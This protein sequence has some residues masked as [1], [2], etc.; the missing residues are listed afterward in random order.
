MKNNDSIAH[1]QELDNLRRQN[2]ELLTK[3]HKLEKENQTYRKIIDYVTGTTLVSNESEPCILNPEMA[4]QIGKYVK[5]Q[6]SYEKAIIASLD[7]IIFLLDGSYAFINVWTNQPENLFLPIEKL[8]GK[9]VR[10]ALGEEFAI[11]FEKLIDRVIQTKERQSIEYL[12][13]DKVSY[14]RAILNY[15]LTD[16]PSS[17]LVSC[18]IRDITQQKKTQEALYNSEKKFRMLVNASYDDIFITNAEGKFI[19]VNQNI[20]DELGY[21]ETELLQMSIFQ[22]SFG[23][24]KFSNLMQVIRQKG[25]LVFDMVHMSKAGE[26]IPVELNM[27]FTTFEGEPAYLGIA[28]NTTER[29]KSEA[30]LRQY[31]NIIDKSNDAIFLIEPKTGKYIDC[32]QKACDILG[33][34]KEELLQKGVIDIAKHISD[35]GILKRRVDFVKKKNGLVFETEYKHKKGS[36]IP[37]EVSATLIDYLNHT[38][39]LAMVRDI[40]KRKQDEKALYQA[41]MVIENSPAVL[42]RRRADKG[43]PVELV[44]GNIIQF[45]YTAHELLSGTISYVDLIH[46]DDLVRVNG[47]TIRNTA[48]ARARF[49][50]EY[51][52]LTAKGDV[53]WVDD[54]TL[55]ERDSRG[56]VTHYQGI[57]MDV[58]D[59]KEA[60]IE[61]QR[62]KE[63][64]AQTN[65]V[66]KVGGWEYDLLKNTLYWSDVTKI[67][68]EV[69]LYFEPNIE[70]AINFYKEG[71]SR[72]RMSHALQEAIEK[73]EPYNLELQIV[74]VRGREVWIN[75]IGKPEFQN[76]VCV[77]L[78][79]VF[80]DIDAKKKIEQ[81]IRNAQIQA[82]RA[83]Q[84]KTAFLANMSHELR[85]PLNGILGFA[86]ILMAD[87]ELNSS[88]QQQVN[89]IFESGQHLLNLIEDILDLS[90]IE[91]GKIELEPEEFSMRQALQSIVSMMEFRASEK[92]IQF[93]Y[94][95]ADD[96]PDRI[97]NDEKRLRQIVLNLLANAIKFTERGQVTFSITRYRD[98]IRFRIEDTGIGMEK[99]DL[100]LLFKPFQQVGEKNY[101]NKGTGLGL[102]TSQHIAELMSSKIY[103]T[104]TIGLGSHFWF[105]LF[106][107]NVL[108]E[109]S[110][111]EQAVNQ[112]PIGYTGERKKVLVVDDE[113]TNRVLIKTFL[114][115]LG[116][117]V[118]LSE[119][120]KQALLQVETW[121]PHLVLLDLM[122][123]VM[124]GFEVCKQIRQLPNSADI[125]VL[126]LSAN[127]FSLTRKRIAEAGS[128]DFIAKP[129]SYHEL[130][131]KLAKLLSL[132]WIYH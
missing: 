117:L 102:A 40:S 71:E 79:G 74:T 85:T 112:Y 126:I 51:R 11:P 42:F 82:E 31:K 129:L 9:T 87:L 36:V 17:Q 41:N 96:V 131:V 118:E 119:N 103:V 30:K 111:S 44:S 100:Q 64:L 132:T 54:R 58:T 25:H 8:L 35:E 37:V 38:M 52:I 20:C 21:T 115:K 46:P 88:Q 91:A 73:S 12:A 110:I 76:G 83:N 4:Q 29:V 109:K 72:E 34:S 108:S 55:I 32:N 70:T 19:F 5:K 50:Q 93:Y 28:R 105:D 26:Q 48:N 78:Y 7:D 62:T 43:W 77:R 114:E 63:M 86:Q 124:D 89:S 22:I 81:E 95:F 92:G 49:S 67:I 39:M 116:F 14:Y 2:A 80:Q 97:V 99:E 53:R 106:I 13:P 33:F 24:D 61:L 16:D 3:Q 69:P 125:K 47:E 107:P 6:E 27:R 23:S 120:G 66:A 130:L 59:R 18:M 84:A 10:Q 45:G 90:K 122:M 101:N 113:M 65:S 104:S 123:P 98:K 128:D 1:L 127:V 121:Q 15:V 75:A 56:Q 57:V 68:H 60:E 94:T